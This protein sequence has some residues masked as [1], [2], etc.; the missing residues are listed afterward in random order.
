MAPG[1][2]TPV[3][4]ERAPKGAKFKKFPSVIYGAMKPIKVKDINTNHRL[5]LGASTCPSQLSVR[6]RHVN[7]NGGFNYAGSPE[8]GIAD[9]VE[10]IEFPSNIRSRD[11]ASISRRARLGKPIPRLQ[12]SDRPPLC[13][14]KETIVCGG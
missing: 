8:I 4:H 7:K 11:S 2:S 13:P 9:L 5:E 3:M 1:P 12:A 14:K 6:S 10:M